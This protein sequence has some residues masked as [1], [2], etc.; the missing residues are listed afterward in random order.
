MN[1]KLLQEW[2][3]LKHYKED[4]G[5]AQ[6]EIT[7]LLFAKKEFKVTLDENQK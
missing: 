3:T 2:E 6:E 4:F 1:G 7:Q 5:T